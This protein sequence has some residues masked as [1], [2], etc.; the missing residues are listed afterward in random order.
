MA[1]S[2][3]FQQAIFGVAGQRVKKRMKDR[4]FKNFLLQDGA[5][6][7]AYHLSCLFAR[8]HVPLVRS[9]M[10]RRCLLTFVRSRPL[11]GCD[12]VA[13]RAAAFLHAKENDTGLLASRLLT[14]TER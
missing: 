9:L 11:T 12:C 6:L 1:I 8:V 2:T 4:M 10:R 14:D 13:M 5:Y 3:A 7:H